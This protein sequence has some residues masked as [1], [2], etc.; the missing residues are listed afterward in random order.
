ML[1]VAF[2]SIVLVALL[3]VIGGALSWSLGFR[4]AWALGLAA[5]F[6]F[7]TIA[8]ASTAAP[9]VGLRWSLLPLGLVAAVLVAGIVVVRRL[10]LRSSGAMTMETRG[11]VFWVVVATVV[12]AIPL[13]ARVLAVF[14]GPDAISQTFDNVFHLNAIR[15]ILESGS[16][17]SLDVGGLTG[18]M[19]FYP[20]VWHASAALLVEVT[21][22]AIPAAVQALTLVVSA[23]V[24]PLSAIVLTSALMGASRSVVLSTGVIAG[25]LPAFPLLMMDYGV[26]YPLQLSFAILPAVLALTVRLLGG[27]AHDRGTLGWWALAFAGALPGLVLSHPGGFVGWIALSSPLFL[28]FAI[29]LWRASSTMPR[30][31]AVLVG[32]VGYL[33]AGIILIKVLRPAAEARGWPPVMSVSAAVWQVVSVSMFL[34][35]SA[36]LVA[37]AVFIGAVRVLVERTASLWAA[38]GMWAVGALLFVVAASI[39][40]WP[41][42][43]A[44]T[45]SWYN[46]WPRLAALLAVALVPLAVAGLD[47]VV[48]FVSRTQLARVRRATGAVVGTVVVVVVAVVAAQ[49]P[50]MPI[51]QADAHEGY[52]MAD[53]AKLLSPDELALLERLPDEVPA[54]AVIAGNPY[55]GTA[56]A[57]AYSD[58]RVLMPHM[59]MYLTAEGH[60]VNEGLDHADQDP[61]VCAALE[62][63]GVTYV[64]DFGDREVH[65]EH[66]DY[67][68]LDELATSAAVELVDEAG[69]ARLYRI[70]ACGLR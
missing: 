55:T 47:G 20:S 45:G 37:V 12:A 25:A 46:N 59:L 7:S 66:H 26:L 62:T 1:T 48:A 27:P 2:A 8:I 31:V 28:L 22:A 40:I 61:E 64:L 41:I 52:V 4:G 13:G 67:E 57:Y 32:A 50:A 23:V 43:D 51:A 58:R 60:L 16:G 10:L 14:G 39:G 53:D 17:S 18:A 5:P 33:G 9:L 29:R 15:Y 3:A 44:L 30:R 19:G 34:G 38:L 42:R 63:L 35:V 65:G 54:D 68:G 56:L 21:G 6:G 70:V 69:D 36:V 49:F 11:G 24:W